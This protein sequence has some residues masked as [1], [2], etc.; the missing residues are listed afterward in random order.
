MNMQSPVL[1]LIIKTT[2]IA[3]IVGQ[4]KNDGIIWRMELKSET[5]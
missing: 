4:K 2:S 1:K 3:W 5:L